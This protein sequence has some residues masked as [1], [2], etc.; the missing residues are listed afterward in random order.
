M[1][2]PTVVHTQTRCERL[3]GQI[4]ALG[5]AGPVTLGLDN[6]RYQRNAVVQALAAE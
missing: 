6:A 3:L 2:N 1:T 4:A 5:L